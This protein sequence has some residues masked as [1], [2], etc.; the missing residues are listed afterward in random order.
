MSRTRA[1]ALVGGVAALTALVGRRGG[2]L[3]G[4]GAAPSPVKVTCNDGL[5]AD[6][7]R[8]EQAWVRASGMPPKIKRHQLKRFGCEWSCARPFR[9]ARFRNLKR[10]DQYAI[11]HPATKRAGWWQAS[12]FDADGP[13]GDRLRDSCDKAVAALS[14]REWAI[15]EWA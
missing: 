5:T 1:I 11:V 10:P 9:V 13:Y 2:P 15:V 3:G 4:L 6:E 8:A 7:R 12:L 14:P